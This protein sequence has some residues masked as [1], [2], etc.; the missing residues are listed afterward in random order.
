MRHRRGERTAAPEVGA[1]RSGVGSRFGAAQIA[2]AVSLLFL[3]ALPLAPAF[4]G[5]GAQGDVGFGADKGGESGAGD[6]ERGGGAPDRSPPVARLGSGG[7]E[8]EVGRPIVFDGSGSTDPDDDIAGFH[9]CFGDA[10]WVEWQSDDSI[11]HVYQEAGTYVIRLWVVDKFGEISAPAEADVT[12]TDDSDPCAGVTCDDDDPCTQ[13]ACVGGECI[14]TPLECDDDDLCTTDACV[15]GECIFTPVDCDDGYFCNG[16]ETCDPDGGCQAG[17]NPCP[18]QMCDE[19]SDECVE[20]LADC[21]CDDGLACED[22]VCVDPCEGNNPPVAVAGNDIEAEV[23]S[24]VWFDGGDSHDSDGSIETYEWEIS[25]EGVPASKGGEIVS[26]AFDT[27]GEYTVTLTVTDNCDEDSDPDTLTV[28]VSASDP[29][30]G[31]LPVIVVRKPSDDDPEEWI[32]ADL[33]AVEMG[34]PLQ[35][36]GTESQGASYHMWNFGDGS[37]STYAIRE[38]TFDEPGSYEVELTIFNMWGMPCGSTTTTV[39]IVTT[40]SFLDVGPGYGDNATD[41]A[42]DED[43]SVMWISHLSSEIRTVDISDPENIQVVDSYEARAGSSI[44]LGEDV[45]YLS[46]GNAGLFTYDRSGSELE[47]LSVFDPYTEYGEGVA[48]ITASGNV[49]F[50]AGGTAGFHVLDMTDPSAPELLQEIPLPDNG[51]ALYLKVIDKGIDDRFAYLTDDSARLHVFDLSAVDVW[52]PQASGPAPVE[53]VATVEVGANAGAMA[54]SEDGILAC[55][56]GNG[57]DFFDMNDP[58]NPVHRS[59]LDIVADLG[60]V[61]IGLVWVGDYLYGGFATVFSWHSGVVRINCTD[62]DEPYSMELLTTDGE[63]AGSLRHPVL[64]DGA[65]YWLSSVQEVVTVAIPE[66]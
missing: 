36:D 52:D 62:L 31:E 9:W 55:A 41:F 61:P 60:A 2:V 29:D 49:V 28:T 43:A 63:A 4:A 65:L 35:F 44:E 12:I 27:E 14:F 40:M 11:E 33:D 3:C 38:H 7:Y 17:A 51:K 34:L 30:P 8:G 54:M 5:Y 16:Q 1:Y 15:D 6:D 46:R 47:L 10:D 18:D 26:H 20:C 37:T 23:G 32:L 48:Q 25:G 19:S 39:T 24:T 59:N 56:T 22:G 21:D 58:Y 13:D 45:L 57:V 66:S 42:L 53:L 64:R 50:A